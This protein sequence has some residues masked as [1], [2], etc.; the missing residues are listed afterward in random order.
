MTP[1]Y[2]QAG[3]TIYHGDCRDI[4]EEWEGLR[5]HPFDLLL[6]DPPYGIWGHDAVSRHDAANGW[7]Q[8][9]ALEWD[10][11]PV[12]AQTLGRCIAACWQACVWGGNY[13]S[14]PPTSGWLVWD[15]GQRE[16]SLAD[17]EL[18]WTSEQRA[19][20]IFSYARGSALRD[21]KQH[22]TQKPQALI[23]WCF[24]QFPKAR[25]VFDPFLGSGTT[26]VE[27]KRIGLVGVGVEREER[28]CEIAANRLRQDALPLEVA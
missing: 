20:R 17:G 27:A 13:F 10:K 6:T 21:G 3:V 8:Y 11:E 23:A 16:F 4:L 24:S 18:A 15:K 19:L 7:A 26:L 12:D 14:L 25:T 2:E 28:Y 1:Y 5:T 9:G 22:P